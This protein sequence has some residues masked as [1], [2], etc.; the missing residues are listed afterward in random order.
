MNNKGLL[1]IKGN[2]Y[3]TK[4]K[5]KA[6]LESEGIIVSS[7]FELDIEKYRYRPTI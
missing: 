4:E 7:D 5:Q 6:L 3:S 1:S 2:F